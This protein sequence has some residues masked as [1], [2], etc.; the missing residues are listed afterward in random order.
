MSRPD[1][2][3]GPDWDEDVDVV[4]IGVNPGVCAFLGLCEADGVDALVLDWPTEI[5]PDTRDYLDQ[6]TTDLTDMPDEPDRPATRAAPD[7]TGQRLETFVG[8]DLRR[9]SARC[10]ASPSGVLF[11]EVP[12]RLTPM[13]TDAGELVTAAR[14]PSLAG[15]PAEPEGTFAGLV[16]EHGRIAGAVVDGGD[17]P[18]LVRADSGLVFALGRSAGDPPAGPDIALVSRRGGRFAR[19]EAL[20]VTDGD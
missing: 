15:A 12:D 13:R 17:T 16:I 6:M 14:V 8:E 9:W 20:A 7:R 5:D 19:L 18:R 1:A 10:L 3:D 11:T 2:G 4:C